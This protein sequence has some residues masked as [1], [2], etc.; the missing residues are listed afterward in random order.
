MSENTNKIF[1]PKTFSYG[2]ELEISNIS[3]SLE[4]PKDLGSWDSSERDCVNTLPPYRG[5]AA[6]PLGINPPVGGEINTYPTVGWQGQV[7]KTA[8][9]LKFFRDNDQTPDVGPTAHGHIH[10]HIPG[11]TENIDALKLLAQYVLQHQEAMIR[12]CGKYRK[13]PDMSGSAVTYMKLDGGRLLRDY[14]VQN[15]W[16]R[17]KTFEEFIQMFARGK[18]GTVP[19]R[20]FRYGIN[21]YSLK[22]LKTCEFRM[23]R[24]TI[25]L[26]YLANSLRACE[27]FMDSALNTGKDFQEQIEQEGLVFQHMLWDRSLWDGLQATK[28]PETRGTKKRRYIQ[29]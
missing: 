17:A 1:D 8:L 25:D 16:S 15:I 14:I 18:N 29:L 3:R 20:P 13:Y 7:E 19:A 28:H 22:W 21:L 10:V 12:L 24:G 27:I 9:L 2:L 6:D 11:L 5:I 4:I 26:R 23:F